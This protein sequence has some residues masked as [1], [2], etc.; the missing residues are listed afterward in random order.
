MDMFNYLP[1]GS[2][3]IV[4]QSTFIV[5]SALHVSKAKQISGIMVRQAIA[6]TFAGPKFLGLVWA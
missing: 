2:I 3:A 5:P 4:F 6:Q 1:L